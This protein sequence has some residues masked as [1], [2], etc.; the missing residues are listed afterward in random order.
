MPRYKVFL[1]EWMTSVVIITD[2]RGGIIFDMESTYLI[3]IFIQQ[4]S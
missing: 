3:A 2:R 4:L 1:T